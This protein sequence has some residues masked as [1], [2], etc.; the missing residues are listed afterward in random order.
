MSNYEHERLNSRFS[1]TMHRTQFLELSKSR[2]QGVNET[3]HLKYSRIGGFMHNYGHE[4]LYSRIE[5]RL[6]GFMRNNEHQLL[7]SMTQAQL[8]GFMQNYGHET[9]LILLFTSSNHSSN[10]WCISKNS[11]LNSK[12]FLNFTLNSL[13]NVNY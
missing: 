12:V 9:L 8:I 11:W 13:L 3:T 4:L 6:I 1:I 2:T 10:Q 5:A 7:N